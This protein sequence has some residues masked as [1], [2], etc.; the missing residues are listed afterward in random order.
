M[1]RLQKKQ[2]EQLLVWIAEGLETD[3]INRRAAVFVPTFKVTRQNVQKYRVSRGVELEALREAGEQDALTQGLALKAE[4]VKKLQQLAVLM[5]RDLF[6]GFLW[7]DQ[8]KSVGSGLTQERIDYQ[9][10]NTG[11][12]TQYRG[13]LDDIA[14]EMGHRKQESTNLNVD[15]SAL[16][17]DQLTRI[18]AGEDILKV[19]AR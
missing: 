10:F 1:A 18:A 14:K 7:L 8:V 9:E 11:E 6:G 4:R 13:V 19:L 17:E 2:K 3:E 12:V 15:Y 16:S 5:E